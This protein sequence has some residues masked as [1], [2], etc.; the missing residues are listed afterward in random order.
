MMNSKD[1]SSS[2][3]TI[4]SR[5]KGSEKNDKL[6]QKKLSEE[7]LDNENS[8]GSRRSSK[9]SIG[10]A[11]EWISTEKTEK[12]KITTFGQSRSSDDLGS[13]ASE[14]SHY[15]VLEFTPDKLISIK[16]NRAGLSYSGHVYA[17]S[18]PKLGDDKKK[19]AKKKEAEVN[20]TNILD[21]DFEQ[22][23]RENNVEMVQKYIEHF[24]NSRRL[25]EKLNKMDELGYTPLSIATKND[26]GLM[27]EVLI[28][29]KADVQAYSNLALFT[30]ARWGNNGALP[31]IL[32]SRADVDMI[33]SN[34]ITPL[35]TA[36]RGNQ[37]DSVILLL[38]Y[39]ADVNWVGKKDKSV[40]G[41]A[42]E[43]GHLE[44]VRLLVSEGAK[45][46]DNMWMEASSSPNLCFNLSEGLTERIRKI[47]RDD[48]PIITLEALYV[49]IES[50][51]DACVL[52]LDTVLIKEMTEG[53]PARADL[54]RL[55]M[56]A[57]YTKHTTYNRSVKALN[58]LCPPDTGAG[59]AVKIRLLQVKDILTAR[60]IYTMY[61]SPSRTIF[62]SV[63]VAQ[64]LE[65]CFNNYCY[66]LWVRDLL[67][68][69]VLLLLFV[70]FINFLHSFDSESYLQIRLCLI[71]LLFI[72]SLFD[73]SRE[74]R[75]CL[76][77]RSCGKSIT[78]NIRLIS[79]II[80]APNFVLCLVVLTTKE[81]F[82]LKQNLKLDVEMP[83]YLPICAICIFLRYVHL[84]SLAMDMEWIGIKVLPIYRSVIGIRPFFLL[85]F[86]MLF[87]FIHATYVFYWN[88]KFFSGV[89][90]FAVRQF[91][92]GMITRW[93]IFMETVSDNPGILEDAAPA[94]A[95]MLFW[96]TLSGFM[97]IIV[98]LQFF[99][100]V[101][102]TSYDEENLWAK[103]TYLRKK[104]QTCFEYFL[105]TKKDGSHIIVKIILTLL[106]YMKEPPEKGLMWMCETL[107]EDERNRE[108][109]TGSG[110]EEKHAFESLHHVLEQSTESI[111][112]AVDRV[113]TLEWKMEQIVQRVY[114]GINKEKQAHLL[115]ALK[116]GLERRSNYDRQHGLTMS[117]IGK[118]GRR[119]LS[120]FSQTGGPGG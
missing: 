114:S 67:L 46:T 113:S 37:V 102:R 6:I 90:D 103:S 69:L 101:L 110:L 97:M 61:K 16:R 9:E 100:G 79:V 109:L 22:L 63:S 13:D 21:L 14:S 117:K 53:V 118:F 29:A 74:L 48:I 119:N 10:S 88:N 20:I 54:G 7:S 11:L 112:M 86:L 85:F 42:W 51:P 49:W 24:G 26:N 70:L 77:A 31:I 58:K 75:I 106:N 19:G 40:L 36:A 8:Y 66:S 15:S 34:H 81:L 35:V 12:T 83:S 5:G 59:C 28:E 25:V 78:A 60:M 98:L 108:D 1:K 120:D 45:L 84:L 91:L 17:A 62:S 111:K 43:L 2:S 44:L 116:Q 32:G 39:Q 82:N 64:L 30:A 87:A 99:V 72:N 76:F 23:I 94:Y 4:R 33:G 56:Q 55:H 80:I 71:I 3:S 89:A 104:A 65:M 92:L 57:V 68:E 47:G 95:S 115:D 105:F 96:Y 52:L 50:C 107:E 27:A 73:F 41:V 38:E 18:D 93:P